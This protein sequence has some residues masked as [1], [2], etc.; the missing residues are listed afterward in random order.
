MRNP[1][2]IAFLHPLNLAMLALAVAAGLCSAWWLFPLGMIFWGLMIYLVARDPSLRMRHSVQSRTPLA[3]RFQKKFERIERLQVNIFNAVNS[4]NASNRR[5]L[6]PVLQEA[7]EL[8]EQAYQLCQRTSPLE[9]FRLVSEKNQ[10]VEAEWV[11]LSQ[12]VAEASD[13]VVQREYNQSLQALERRLEK[14]HQTLAYLDRV[15][16]QLEG[17]ASTMQSVLTEVIRLQ[18][19]SDE[20]LQQG[21]EA[22]LITLR[23]EK[24]ELGRA[25]RA[26]EEV[27]TL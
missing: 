19:M 11:R 3:G 18:A 5:A 2:V 17:L 9:N 25:E 6:R 13:P 27:N 23:H 15:D 20:N 26:P 22:L 7:T 16:A 1:V 4:A 14:H 10:D 12:Q 24:E 21:C 8:T